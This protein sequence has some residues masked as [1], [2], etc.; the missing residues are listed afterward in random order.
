[1]TFG[2]KGLVEAWALHTLKILF[3]TGVMLKGRLMSSMSPPKTDVAF[4][5]II[6]SK[7]HINFERTQ[8]GHEFSF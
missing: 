2:F 7:S 4:K 5:I 3:L 1:M 6:G 8:G